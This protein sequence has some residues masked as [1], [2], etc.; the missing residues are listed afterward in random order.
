M[1]L[2]SNGRGI[3][4][5]KALTFWWCF[6][7][8]SYNFISYYI[9]VNSSLSK[10]WW[11]PMDRLTLPHGCT[12][13]PT[14]SWHG[15]ETWQSWTQQMNQ[16]RWTLDTFFTATLLKKYRRHFIRYIFEKNTD[17]THWIIHDSN[18]FIQSR[19]NH[20]STHKITKNIV[21]NIS[22]FFVL[23]ST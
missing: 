23:K 3:A 6:V 10:N 9:S 16:H 19:I 4:T 17:S 18:S 11:T 22:K 5:S 21:S 14:S 15:V 20:C 2:H 7:T 1:V 13:S 12:A 8:G